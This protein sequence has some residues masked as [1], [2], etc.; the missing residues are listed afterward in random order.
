MAKTEKKVSAEFQRQLAESIRKN[1][2][3]LDELAKL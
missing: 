1:K 2:K 3:A